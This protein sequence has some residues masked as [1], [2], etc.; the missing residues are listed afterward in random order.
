M[1]CFATQNGRSFPKCVG[2][3]SCAEP[4]YCVQLSSTSAHFAISQGSS[5]SLSTHGTLGKTNCEALLRESFLLV[6]YAYA[7]DGRKITRATSVICKTLTVTGIH[8]YS[9]PIP[10][11]VCCFLS[12]ILVVHV[13]LMLAFA[14][15]IMCASSD[16][17]RSGSESTAM[18]M[19]MSKHWSQVAK[20]GMSI[21]EPARSSAHITTIYQ[22]GEVHILTCN[23]PMCTKTVAKYSTTWVLTLNSYSSKY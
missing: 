13:Y 19:Y 16:L 6:D 1:Y 23:V 8:Y 17:I 18:A 9:Y 21:L 2:M 7:C 3:M 5:A 14:T 4:L 11:I 22:F 12:E 20:P 15:V 10:G